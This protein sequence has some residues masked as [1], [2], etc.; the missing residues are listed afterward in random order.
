MYIDLSY[1][2]SSFP[3]IKNKVT[4]NLYKSF[5]F[6][7]KKYLHIVVFSAHIYRLNFL[8]FVSTFMN[9]E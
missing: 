4:W 8:S 1:L 2:N 9:M 7:Q 5:K 3:Y 6:L